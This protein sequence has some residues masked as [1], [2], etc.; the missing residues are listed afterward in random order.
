M[1][2]WENILHPVTNPPCRT[3]ASSP[4][5]LAADTFKLHN[6]WII[7]MFYQG[8]K[9]VWRKLCTS[10]TRQVSWQNACINSGLVNTVKTSAPIKHFYEVKGRIN[11]FCTAAPRTGAVSFFAAAAAREPNARSISSQTKHLCDVSKRKKKRKRK[12]RWS[13]ACLNTL[14]LII[15]HIL[16]RCVEVLLYKKKGASLQLVSIPYAVRQSSLTQCLRTLHFPCN[17]SG[18]VCQVTRR[19]TVYALPALLEAL[20]WKP[21]SIC[22]KTYRRGW[23]SSASSFLSPSSFT[24]H[25]PCHQTGQKWPQFHWIYK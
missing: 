1:G 8:I 12:G 24:V 3:E 16:V 4:L 10:C 19:V 15:Y 22:K 9:Q 17:N 11:R 14:T 18:G 21:I 25:Q 6:M 20:W 7:A 5:R 2:L 23:V 13:T